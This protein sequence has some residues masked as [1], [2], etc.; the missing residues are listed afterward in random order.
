MRGILWFVIVGFGAGLWTYNRFIP[1]TGKPDLYLVI[2]GIL[3]NAALSMGAAFIMS[4]FVLKFSSDERYL[5]LW[6]AIAGA[7]IWPGRCGSRL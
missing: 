6:G 2:K 1:G 5:G 4:D 7:A 3:T